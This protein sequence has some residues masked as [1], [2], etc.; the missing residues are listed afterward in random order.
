MRQRRQSH[1]SSGCDGRHR[2]HDRSAELH[3]GQDFIHVK[4]PATTATTSSAPRARRER[5][6]RS[7]SIPAPTTA[8]TVTYTD[9]P[10]KVAT[11]YRYRV[12]TVL[13][14]STAPSSES[15]VTTKSLGNAN[16]DITTDITANRTL[17]ADT[18]YTLKGFIHVTNGATLTIQP[19]TKIKGDFN[20]LGSSLF[21]M[22]GAKINAVGTA[23]LPI[24]F[25]SSRAAGQRQ[26]GDWGGLILVGNAPT[27]ARGAVIVEGTGTD[28]TA[29][30]ERK[31]LRSRC[32]PAAPRRPT[33]RGTLSYVRVE[34][35]GYAP[36]L[37]NELN[38]FTFAAVGSGTRISYLQS[39]AGLDDA[40]EFFGGGFD[41]DHLVA[42]ET[43]DDMFDMSEGFVGPPAVPH[44]L[45]LGA[46]HAAHRRRLARDGPRRHRERRLQRH[47]AAING[48]NSTPFTVPLVA[49][50]T[51]VGCGAQSCVGPAG[52]FGMMLRRG[53]GGYY[54]NGVVARFPR[55][56]VSLRDPETL[57]RAARASRSRTSR[58]PICNSQCAV[59]GNAGGVPGEHD[60][61][62]VAVRARPHRQR[63]DEQRGGIRQRCSPRFRRRAR[64]RPAWRRSTGRRS[65]ARR[66]RPADWRR[67][68]A[69]SRRRQARSWPERATS[70]RSRQ[71]ARSGGQAG[72][73][74]FVTENTVTLSGGRRRADAAHLSIIHTLSALFNMKY[75]RML[76]VL[77]S[78]SAALLAC[79]SAKTADWPCRISNGLGTR[80]LDCACSTGLHQPR[81]AGIRRRLRASGG[82]RDSPVSRGCRRRR[83]RR[84]PRRERVADGAR[85]AFCSRSRCRRQRR[86]QARRDLGPRVRRSDLSDISEHAPAL[87]AK[88][89]VRLDA[90]RRTEYKSV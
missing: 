14:S 46:A 26:P 71:A 73:R 28:G 23:D 36:S 49:N 51:L 33:T 45:Q 89:G 19:G 42:Y 52:G 12:I 78:P 40:F 69:R 21:I 9:T 64:C 8:G 77:A 55:G 22:R 4:A 68:R 44:R 32:T 38:S 54:V 34:F 67:S 47:R 90:N 59:R 17:T 79:D 66:S 50:F 29:V 53:T 87:P 62:G 88:P 27:T 70:A 74:T 43:G 10:L 80:G 25:T 6:R 18:V 84:A 24:V 31:E 85:Q 83:R 20:T 16:A 37:N 58:R 41:G 30:V 82:G 11:L 2:R 75:S 7:T 86:S 13:G 56:G 15:S 35:A 48:F 61:A 39:M 72:R 60:H 1:S 76:I 65:P 63:A 81:V 3:V 57:P 5:S